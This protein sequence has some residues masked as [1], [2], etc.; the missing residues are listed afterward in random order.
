MTWASVLFGVIVATL[1]GAFFHLWRGGNLTRLIFYLF[2]SEVGFWVGQAVASNLAWKI[3]QYGQINFLLASLGSF[4]FLGGG[5]WLS[6]IP[7]E[8]T[9]KK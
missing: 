4:L 6:S 8:K 2:L 7:G 5:Y 1:I 9:G 3:G